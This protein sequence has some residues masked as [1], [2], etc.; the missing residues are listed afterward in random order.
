[1]NTAKSFGAVGDGVADDT[2]AVQAWLDAGGYRLEDGV[3]RI[4]STLTLAGNGR[5]FVTDGARLLGA[6]QDMTMMAVTGDDC[7]ISA[8]FAGNSLAA[9]G[10]YVTGARALIESGR[11][12]DIRSTAV[13]DARAINVT[14]AGGV[15]VRRNIILRTHNA[16]AAGFCRAIAVNATTA[17]SGDTIITDNR[18]DGVTGTE[19]DAIQ[20]L[21]NDGGNVFLDARAVIARNNIRNASRRFI[22]VQGSNTVVKDNIIRFDIATAPELPS[23]YINAFQSDNVTITGNDIGTGLLSNPI[24][25][26]GIAARRSKGI[27]IRNNVIRQDDARD[28][29]SVY[30]DYVEDGAIT[31]NLCFGGAAGVSVGNSINVLV[32]GAVGFGGLSTR[33]VVRGTISN[34]DVTVRSSANMNPARTTPILL[35]GTGHKAEL[36]YS[37]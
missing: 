14:T 9:A 28:V 34:T 8:H 1:M 30:L 6:T 5:T 18:I 22:K 12:E 10:V 32:D 31:D 36:N 20:I 7:T 4:T 24:A 11:Y 13:Q 26:T 35:D 25:V 2:A 29:A 19:G 21:F 17:A 33:Q 23:N 27:T 15:T 37:R 3:Y 16:K